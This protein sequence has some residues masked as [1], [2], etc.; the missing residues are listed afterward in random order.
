MAPERSA[1]PGA[2]SLPGI[3]NSALASAALT[4]VA[5]LA[6]TANAAPSLGDE[7]PSREEVSRRVSSLYDRAESDTGTFNATRA[8]A[9]GPRGRADRPTGA[10]GTTAAAAR[11]DEGRRSD[12][13]VDNVARQWFDVARSKLGPTVPAALPAD[14]MPERPAET[15]R[16]RP[17]ERAGDGLTDRG[18][19]PSGRAALELPAAPVAELTSPQV[20][21][22]AAV[23]E[24]TAGPIAALPAAPEAPQE[25]AQTDWSTRSALALPAP[26]A[27]TAEPTA[28]PAAEPK[29][30]PQ[31][32]S[33][34]RTAK[35]Q[36]Q[37]K[38]ARAREL[39]SAYTA[40]QST[41]LP[42]IETLPAAD[43]WNTAPVEL[44]PS[45]DTQWQVLRA[46]SAAD[47]TT[48]PPGTTARPST[49]SP[50]V[51][52]L[53]T[54]ATGQALDLGTALTSTAPQD[55]RAVRA[56]D[57]ARAQLGKPC[58]WGTTG[59][60]AY[61]GPGL[62]QAAWRAAGIT[63]P[64]TAQ[65]QATAGQGIA[66]AYLEPGDLVLFHIGHV[67]IYSGNGMMIHAPGPG[68]AIREESIHYAGESAIHSAIRPA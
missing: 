32:R 53:A 26:P 59:P 15:R 42:A 7:T 38:L 36:N 51:D 41:P 39:L 43:T 28:E 21:G 37:R 62:T 29:A 14:R 16:A 46:Q 50:T 66:L 9:T 44:Q 3:R 23:V 13:A 20:T 40:P 49:T 19:E 63:L 56:L 47:L 67:G 68:A 18:R 1:R 2:L 25:A 10:G 17:A 24:L 54:G 55:T 31:Q 33:S 6:Q 58:V 35:E 61:D 57:F 27:P 12:P 45:A 65:E 34:L 11:G 64:R 30:D 22:T 8:A 60:G 52:A 4:S 48:V 5:L